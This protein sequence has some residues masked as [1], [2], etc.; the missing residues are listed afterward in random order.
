MPG[1]LPKRHNQAGF[2][3]FSQSPSPKPDNF[4]DWKLRK[5]VQHQ[6]S[7]LPTMRLQTP[8]AKPTTPA[9][10]L[11]D[12]IQLMARVDSTTNPVK[13]GSVARACSQFFTP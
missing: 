3:C 8:L 5:A 7:S 13:S 11:V 2:A 6:P 1:L 10:P 9:V 4:F 12:K